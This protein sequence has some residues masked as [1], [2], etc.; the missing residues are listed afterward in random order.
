MGRKD[1]IA[2]ISDALAHP[3]RQDIFKYIMRCNRERRTVRN[4]DLVERFPY[5]QATISQH[6]NKL[7]IGGLVE[8]KREGVSSC[9][10]ANIGVIGQYIDL[11]RDF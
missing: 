7:I 6:L 10:F 1:Q 2:K 4:K 9:Y 3:A 11:L 5:A 8:V